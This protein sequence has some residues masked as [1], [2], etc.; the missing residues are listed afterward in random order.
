VS[1]FVQL[2]G[3]R[4]GGG[5]PLVVLAGPC[6]IE[7]RD[8]A[9]ELAAGLRDLATAKGVGLVFKASF[10]KANRTSL[11]SFRGPGLAEGLAVLQAIKDS[12]GLPVLTDIHEPVQAAAAAEVVDLLQIPAFLCRQTDLLQ[13]AGRT[14][15]PVNIKKGQFLAPFDMTYAAEKVRA[16]GGQPLLTERGSSFGYRD[17]V[18]DMRSLVW[19]RAAG[20]P[21][22]FDGTHSVQQPGAARGCT[23]G[24]REMIRP[25]VRAAVAVGVDGIYLEVH[26]DPEKAR[27]DGPN[28]LDLDS[29]ERVL[30]EIL[31]LERALRFKGPEDGSSLVNC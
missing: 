27:C 16:A 26:P 6:V 1:A 22:L 14:G 9:L 13:A 20:V 15:K 11:N 30:D 19:M 24:L 29:F 5:A 2:P 12:T 21:V 18:V 3:M 10:D 8:S 28:C 4:I 25:L 17:L 31:V 7:D 23:G